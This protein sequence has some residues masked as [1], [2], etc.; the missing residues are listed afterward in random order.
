MNNYVGCTM[1]DGFEEQLELRRLT[2]QDVAEAAQICDRCVGKNM[3]TRDY[4]A[5]IVHD[6]RH[7]FYLLFSKENKTVGYIYSIVMNR[8]ELVRFSKLDA[9]HLRRL[10]DKSDANIGVLRSIGLDEP[11]RRTG[12]SV[13]LVRFSLAGLASLGARLVVVLCWKIDEV[14]PLRKTLEQ[15]GMKY[16]TDAHRVWHDMDDL[17]CPYC[18][19]RCVC[20]AEVYYKRLEAVQ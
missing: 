14:V 13:E 3:Y 1:Q 15:C 18:N 20:D 11:F 5:S 9:K 12:L 7:L 2:D 6:P 17:V 19:G 16:L 4:L 10:C 8:E